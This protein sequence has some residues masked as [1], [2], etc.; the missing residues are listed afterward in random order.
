MRSKRLFAREVAYGVED[1][2]RSEVLRHGDEFGD[3]LTRPVGVLELVDSEENDVDA[4]AGDLL[5][6]SAGPF[7]RC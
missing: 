5:R 7:R 6:E 3:G 4:E 2:L 1:L